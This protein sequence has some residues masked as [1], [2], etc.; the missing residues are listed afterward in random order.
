ME[1]NIDETSALYEADESSAAF[2]TRDFNQAADE[3]DLGVAKT[4]RSLT[5]LLYPEDDS[6]QPDDEAFRRICDIA[7]D[8]VRE[9]N[10]HYAGAAGKDE[11]WMFPAGHASVDEKGGVLLE[12]WQGR[13]YC[14]LL[15][16]GPGASAPVYIFCKQGPEDAGS[17]IKSDVTGNL[18]ANR[19]YWLNKFDERMACLSNS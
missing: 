7:E 3:W 8:A 12:W 2:S 13:A 9:I 17:M 1:A 10:A 15:G 16:V 19:L 6:P 4:I 18:L 11:C 14:V 5:S